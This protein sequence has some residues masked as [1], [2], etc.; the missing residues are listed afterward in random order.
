[1]YTGDGRE[2]AALLDACDDEADGADAAD[3]A[4]E[5]EPFPPAVELLLVADQLLL[6]GLRG[7][8]V[9]ALQASLSTANAAS[10]LSV[11][12]D[13]TDDAAC[14]SLRRAC[15]GHV[16]AAGV[17]AARLASG[18]A[19]F[20]AA[21]SPMQ[22]QTLRWLHA[23]SK[24]NPLCC[25]AELVDPGEAVALIRD[26]LREQ[27]ERL[28][29]SE[30]RLA[31]AAPGM[32]AYALERSEKLLENQ[33]RHLVY[34]GDFL[35]AQ[36][37]ALQNAGA[38]PAAARPAAGP[39]AMSYDWQRVSD[40][41]PLPA[42]LDIRVDISGKA[43]RQVRIPPT[44]KLRLY[45]PEWRTLSLAVSQTTTVGDVLAQVRDAQV[46]DKRRAGRHSLFDATLR[47]LDPERTFDAALWAD[48]AGLR[49]V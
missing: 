3:A 9:Q 2:L 28:S 41:T 34:I 40:E 10:L 23:V 11:T 19:V 39:V 5:S 20:D 4:G 35:N 38:A 13:L 29:E 8:L 15:L 37:G 24:S 21:F 25:G 33:R 17:D 30:K 46:R 48:R 12:A 44:W 36:E 49:L 42:G 31:E 14:D 45:V 22:A 6:G 47:A 18:D 26:S 43:F 7:T 1:V 32:A 27:E 16:V